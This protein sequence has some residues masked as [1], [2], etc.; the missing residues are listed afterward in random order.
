MTYETFE[1]WIDRFGLRAQLGGLV[2]TAATW[3]AR[4]APPGAGAEARAL[5][6]MDLCLFFCLDDAPDDGAEAL[7]AGYERVLDGAV[8]TP[9]ASPLLHAWRDVV[10][11]VAA[12][13]APLARYAAGR[14]TLV[15]AYR[16]RARLRRGEALDL[17][18][19]LQLRVATIYMDPWVSLWELLDG[20]RP[21]PPAPGP[22]EW[23]AIDAV[24][25]W[26]AMRN[27]L[28]SL[29]RDA[30]RGEANLVFLLRDR[31]GLALPAAA[32]AAERMAEEA[33][34]AC[35]RRIAALPQ[36]LEGARARWL[37][38]LLRVSVRGAEA[39]YH[40]GDPRRYDR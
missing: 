11:R 33:R 26:Q 10:L 14:H 31:D 22:A 40:R 20:P 21:L 1:R 8:P 5:S 6:C 3:V 38:D 2:H 13:G 29:R 25:R 15:A 23:A 18:G 4:C 12:L 24:G 39:H 17:Q 27:D 19:Y 28:A 16:R 34:A 9:G 36:A 30:A 32:A 37:A 35:D 7:R